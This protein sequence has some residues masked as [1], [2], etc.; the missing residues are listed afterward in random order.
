MRVHVDNRCK[1]SKI[2]IRNIKRKVKAILEFLESTDSEV[3][4]SLVDNKEI[5]EL[6]RRYLSRSGITNVIAFPMREGAFPD[7]SPQLIG[8]VV[9]SL[10]KAKSEA[11]N[12]GRTEEEHF[13]YLIIHGILHLLGYDHEESE[14]KSQEMEEKERTTYNFLKDSSQNM[15]K[16]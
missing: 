15:T 2:S 4:I 6:N 9:I 3:S 7:I 13:D 1:N 10:E 14:E 11:I 8:D 16:S 12:F 5:E